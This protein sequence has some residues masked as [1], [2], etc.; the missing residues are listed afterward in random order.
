MEMSIGRII[1]TPNREGVQEIF[2][3]GLFQ[4]AESGQWI[5]FGK[6]LTP[7]E[8]AQAKADGNFISAALFPA[9]EPIAR[10]QYFTQ[11]G[12]TVGD[13]LRMVH[14][15]FGAQW[16]WRAEFVAQSADFFPGVRAVA[17]YADAACTQ[18]LYTTGAFQ[19]DGETWFTEWNAGAGA[20]ADYHF[21]LLFASNQEAIGTL[22]AAASEALVALRHG[23]IEE[24]GDLLAE[25]SAGRQWLVGQYC[26]YQ[27]SVYSCLQQH[28]AQVG[29]E[30]PVV[31]ALWSVIA[32]K[33]EPQPDAEWVDTG[34][35]LTQLIASG[36]YLCSGTPVISLNQPVKLG[37]AETVFTGYWPTTETPS[38]YIKISP[39]KGAA[40]GASIG[41][42]V[43]KWE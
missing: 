39:H 5:P 20:K 33:P 43:Y 35:T 36:V 34:V 31:P 19:Q 8:Y 40:D 24:G 18:Y 37:T 2:V 28:T 10:K 22:D 11:F 42:T 26:T 21:A 41:S 1:E 3:D 15:Q 12:A 7:E 17:I 38:N 32:Q 4:D 27:G 13:Q 30:P 6:W 16:G 29:W 9:Q 25:W 23:L 14:K